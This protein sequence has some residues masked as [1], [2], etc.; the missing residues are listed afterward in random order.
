MSERQMIDLARGAIR[1]GMAKTPSCQRDCK[2]VP[3]TSIPSAARMF[4]RRLLC[5]LLCVPQSGDH[6]IHCLRG[7]GLGVVIRNDG[8]V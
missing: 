2:F 6:G 4:S 5:R 7:F 1:L 3:R 8:T